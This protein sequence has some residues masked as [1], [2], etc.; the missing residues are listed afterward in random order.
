[1]AA[2][3]WW[4]A[5]AGSD[6][7]EVRRASP[8]RNAMAGRMRT[9]SSASPRTH[10][11]SYG[12]T[13]GLPVRIASSPRVFAVEVRR[14]SRSADTDFTV[15]LLERQRSGQRQRIPLEQ[16]WPIQGAR[17]VGVASG[18]IVATERRRERAGGGAEAAGASAAYPWL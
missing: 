7:S 6:L 8:A 9:S 2:Y 14:R 16:R 5:R 13:P 15:P 12:A 3:R 17:A 10:G 18:E 4:F 1:M 11:W